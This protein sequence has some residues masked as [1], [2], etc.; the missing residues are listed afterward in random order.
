[1]FHRLCDKPQQKPLL[2]V[3]TNSWRRAYRFALWNA[4]VFLTLSWWFLVVDSGSLTAILCVPALF[5]V[6]A[7]IAFVLLI[8]SGGAFAALAWFPLGPGVYFG[9]GVFVG[10]LEPDPRSIHYG[11]AAALSADLLR[12]NA[13]N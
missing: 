5:F 10:G 7:V 12:V 4:L 2:S 8:R 9:I 3:C 1:M 13:L 11:S 6:G